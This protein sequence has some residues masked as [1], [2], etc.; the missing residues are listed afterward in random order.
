MPSPSAAEYTGVHP[1]YPGDGCGGFGVLGE[2]MH[3]AMAVTT[4]HDEIAHDVVRR[5]LVDVVDVVALLPFGLTSTHGAQPLAL[6][7]D[8]N[9]SLTEGG[10]QVAS[11]L[12]AV[13]SGK[14]ARSVVA[15][16]V[17]SSLQP[18]L[19]A[20]GQG[21]RIDRAVT[22]SADSKT[23][24]LLGLLLSPL[25]VLALALIAVALA[26]VDFVRTAAACSSAGAQQLVHGVLVDA[27]TPGGLTPGSSF[28]VRSEYLLPVSC[29]SPGHGM[30]PS[31]D[32][33]PCYMKGS[34]SD[35]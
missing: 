12:P 13:G 9:T 16:V 25:T 34:G 5:V 3:K 11:P 27:K 15:P 22:S 4:Q 21:W 35:S 31:V 32:E 10:Q 20:Q 7:P 1:V 18:V 28:F 33:S 17:L 2:Q 26:V 8:L 23:L 14:R 19:R 30:S 6:F 29:G 24:P